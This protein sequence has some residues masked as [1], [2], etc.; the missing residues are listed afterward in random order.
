[1]KNSLVFDKNLYA[2]E[3]CDDIKKYAIFRRSCPMVFLE[4]LFEESILCN[5][6]LIDF[7]IR[8]H[9]IECIEVFSE[10]TPL[11]MKIAGN[12]IIDIFKWGN[13]FSWKSNSF[14]KLWGDFRE[15]ITLLY[16]E[17]MIL[18]INLLFAKITYTTKRPSTREMWEFLQLSW[19]E[20][21]KRTIGPNLFFHVFYNVYYSR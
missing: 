15:Q 4:V 14:H 10:N 12:L 7:F 1:M 18:P 6:N 5:D 2:I 3:I 9:V 20:S 16:Y 11:Q 8:K 17:R 21:Q 19:S 13:P